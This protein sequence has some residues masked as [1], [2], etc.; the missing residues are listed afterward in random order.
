MP[1]VSEPTAETRMHELETPDSGGA[2]ASSDP[3]PLFRPRTPSAIAAGNTGRGTRRDAAAQVDNGGLG[4]S[5]TR[6]PS[7]VAEAVVQADVEPPDEGPG[8]G[9]APDASPNPDPAWTRF[10]IGRALQ[11]LR[12]SQPGVVRRALRRLHLRWFHAPFARMETLLQAA[13]IPAAVVNMSRQIVD[14]CQVCRSWSR[15]APRAIATSSL[16]SRFNQLIQCDLLCTRFACTDV[17]ADRNTNT[18]LTSLQNSWFKH[19]GPPRALVVDQE[20]G[21]TGPE[22]ASWLEARGV[23]LDPKARNQH[24]D[25][26]ERHHEV[27]RRQVHLLESHTLTQRLLSAI[28]VST[29][30]LSYIW[31][32]LGFRVWFR[33][34]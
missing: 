16:P 14:T 18:L 5:A 4:A 29:W 33:A 23:Q 19:F 7:R 22:A 2:A 24:A 9:S 6:G 11:E 15:P 31:E 3:V 32:H 28:M 25:M 26:I 17:V 27:L 1:H 8:Q 13:G 10:D 20:G 21:L 12:S 34:K 30:G